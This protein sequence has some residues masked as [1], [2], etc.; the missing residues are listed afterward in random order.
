MPPDRAK[1]WDLSAQPPKWAPPPA[2]PRTSA[3]V[4]LALE[5]STTSAVARLRQKLA[6]LVSESGMKNK[7]PPLTFERWRCAAVQE[8]SGAARGK[9]GGPHPVLPRASEA[10]G[11]AHTELVEALQAHGLNAGISAKVASAL[12]EEAAKLFAQATSRAH[13]LASGQKLPSAPKVAVTLNKRTVELG[14]EKKLVKLPL[15]CYGKLAALH[16]RHAPE[17]ERAPALPADAAGEEE[18]REVAAAAAASAAGDADARASFHCRLLTLCLRHESTRSTSLQVSL[19]S[20]VWEVLRSKLGVGVECFSSPASCYLPAFTSAFSADVDAPFGS[21]GLFQTA[22]PLAGSFV[23][24]PPAVAAVADAAAEHVLALLDASAAAAGGPALSFFVVLPTCAPA[25]T[26][27]AAVA[28]LRAAAKGEQ[29][30]GGGGYARLSSSPFLRREVRFGAG[31]LGF[32]HAGAASTRKLEE[33]PHVISDREIACLVLQTEKAA[34]KWPAAD[35]FEKQLRDAFAACVPA[36]GAA[37]AANPAA[38]QRKEKRPRRGDE[39]DDAKGGA[40]TRGGDAPKPPRSNQPRRHPNDPREE[41]TK[42][43]KERAKLTRENADGDPAQP[44]G[45]G[46][47]GGQAAPRKKLKPGKEERAARRAAREAESAANAAG[48]GSEVS[49]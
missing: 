15:R 41:R 26:S 43:R 17:A 49:L 36:G 45:G 34:R 30:G 42:R 21:R 35:A 47:E 16:R 2:N 32:V 24:A 20:G 4:A 18:E 22:K 27:A 9:G 46:G 48:G 40:W 28:A 37:G 33:Q 14:C 5:L 1:L 31:T 8:E 10:G 3:Q 7:V 12:A 29:A 11:R 19:G 44:G 6:E 13:R 25:E 23:V 39:A 38:R